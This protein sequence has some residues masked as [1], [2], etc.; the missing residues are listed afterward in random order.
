MRDAL[1]IKAG[2]A[3]VT[4]MITLFD[5]RWEDDWNEIGV[6]PKSVDVAIA[7]RSIMVRDL[8]EAIEKLES[9]ARRQA[10]ITVSTRF[11]PRAERETG[12]VLNGVPYL[13]DSV[14][15]TNILFDME[16][17]PVISYIDACKKTEDGG[18]RLVRWAFLRW[19]VPE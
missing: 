10:A 1:K 3:G 19:D 13:P 12:N 6:V 16:R 8:V 17:Y 14:Y 5:M 15:A 2:E 18:R 11:G 9:V 4:D 7:S